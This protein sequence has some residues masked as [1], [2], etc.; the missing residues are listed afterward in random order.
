MGGM[1]GKGSWGRSCCR[2]KGGGS[3]ARRGLRRGW[4]SQKG[5]GLGRVMWVEVGTWLWGLV[6]GMFD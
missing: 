2:G 6:R 3:K 5:L 1:C 4:E